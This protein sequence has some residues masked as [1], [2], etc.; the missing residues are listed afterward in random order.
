MSNR[1]SLRR[2]T[3]RIGAAA[4]EAAVVLPFVLYLML[5]LWEVGRMV[6]V[7]T[8]LTNS[9]RE[10]A[11]LA[12]GGQTAGTP[13]TVAMVQQDLKN[14]LTAA[15]FPTSAVNVAVVT[16]TYLSGNS[17]TDPCDASPNDHFR[18]TVTIPSGAAYSSLQL[19]PVPTI[20][21]TTSL[22]VSI[23]WLSSNDSLVTVNAQLPY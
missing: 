2:T 7:T 3:K 12:A 11:R 14:Y 13:V 15:G 10:A 8:I 20:T 4:V 1:V 18:V 23:D 16:L 5:G 21:G 19:S 6:W 9:C 22:T 17:W